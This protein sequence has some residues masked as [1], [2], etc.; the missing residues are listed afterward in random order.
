MISCLDETTEGEKCDV[1]CED[2]FSYVC[3]D[4]ST[5]TFCASK[6]AT[7]HFFDDFACQGKNAKVEINR[8]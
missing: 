1:T 5:Q 8:D 7:L 4:Q 6:D 3:A 2:V